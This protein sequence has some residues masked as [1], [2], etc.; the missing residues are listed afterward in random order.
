M[1]LRKDPAHNPQRAGTH[2]TG[3]RLLTSKMQKEGIPLTGPYTVPNYTLETPPRTSFLLTQ[4]Y[5][6]TPPWRM[7]SHPVKDAP[8]GPAPKLILTY[9]RSFQSV[10]TAVYMLVIVSVSLIIKDQQKMDSLKA[11]WISWAC[12]KRCSYFFITW[13]KL[14]MSNTKEETG[15]LVSSLMVHPEK[16]FSY[17]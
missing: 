17:S 3:S 16:G 4:V 15:K 6:S 2:L 7:P 13:Q 11:N 8:P 9:T 14:L 12:F 1:S 10:H 5:L